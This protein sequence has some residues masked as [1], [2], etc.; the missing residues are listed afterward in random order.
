MVELMLDNEHHAINYNQ[1]KCVSDYYA[2]ITR[3]TN[4]NDNNSTYYQYVPEHSIE[5]SKLKSVF[6]HVYS[7][8]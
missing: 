4:Q 2:R 5:I 7:T 1:I 3:K 8:R 6:S